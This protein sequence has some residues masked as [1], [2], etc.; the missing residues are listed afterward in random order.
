MMNRHPDADALAA[1]HEH[2]LTGRAAARIA[3]HLAACPGCAG[4]SAGLSEVSSRLAAI[5]AP[6]ALPGPL[7]A[8]LDAALADEIRRA[9]ATSPEGGP[10]RLAAGEP[11]PTGPATATSPRRHPARRR[12]ALRVAALAAA[13]MAVT[14]GIYGLSRIAGSSG[15]QASSSAAGV[16]PLG[17]SPQSAAPASGKHTGT[18]SS[19]KVTAPATGLPLI[20]SGTDYRRGHLRAQVRSVLDRFASARNQALSGHASLARE[21]PHLGACVSAVADGRTPALVDVARYE[22]RPAAV[23]VISGG[24]GRTVWVVGTGCSGSATD[25]ISRFSLP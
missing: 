25:V 3:S 10:A 6:A 19:S 9:A 8:R 11:A 17:S 16:V 20:E 2:L 5:A 7:A 13:A 14:G 23:I 18:G 15:S 4:V 21:V 1:Y 12:L 22:G 24:G